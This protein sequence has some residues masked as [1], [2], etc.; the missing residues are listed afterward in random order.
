MKQIMKILV[1][2]DDAMVAYLNQQ[3][4][5]RYEETA[6]VIIAK[7]A[8]IASDYLQSEAFDL[9]LL[10]IFMPNGSGLEILKKFHHQANFILLT[11]DSSHQTLT[12]AIG[13]GA[14]DYLLKPYS[15]ERFCTAMERYRIVHELHRTDVK[16]GQQEIDAYFLS[17]KTQSEIPTI[18]VQGEVLAKGLSKQT[19]KQVI[20]V[21]LSEKNFASTIEIAEQMAISRIST[22]K[23]IDELVAKQMLEEKIIYLRKGRPVIKYQVM[24]DKRYELEQLLNRL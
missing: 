4:C 8:Q 22:K 14:L 2:E 6:T 13:F 10:D 1:V 18:Q 9:I 11:A 12:E 5:L 21:F 20:K 7:D 19:M 3:F 24:S 16:L 17:Q 15:Y 23:Y